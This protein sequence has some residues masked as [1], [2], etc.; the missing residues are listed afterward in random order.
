L[1][2]EISRQLAATDALHRPSPAKKQKA[3]SSPKL[4]RT[5][6]GPLQAAIDA[7]QGPSPAKKQK[8]E[9]SKESPERSGET[10]EEPEE[11]EEEIVQ[12]VKFL[13]DVKKGKS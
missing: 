6:S 5:E 8:E 10:E 4:V 7:L 3:P 13:L 1:I 11:D 12:L 9:E 2:R